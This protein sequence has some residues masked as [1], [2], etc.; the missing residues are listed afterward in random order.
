MSHWRTV[1]AAERIIGT[2][3]VWEAIAKA[4]DRDLPHFYNVVAS[5]LG[6]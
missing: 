2:G 1:F 4:V 3:M 6:L 5:A